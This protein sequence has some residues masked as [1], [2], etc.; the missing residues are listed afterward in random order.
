MWTLE[1]C[2]LLQALQILPQM[3]WNGRRILQWDTVGSAGPFWAKGISNLKYSYKMLFCKVVEKVMSRVHLATAVEL[4][5]APVLQSR[6]GT[7]Q[8][9]LV[10]QHLC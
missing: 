1:I 3:L 7:E 8:M 2:P 9:A 10:G 5:E 6:A 4:S